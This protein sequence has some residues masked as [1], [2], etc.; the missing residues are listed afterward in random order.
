AWEAAPFSEDTHVGEDTAFVWR[1]DPGRLHAMDDADF[2]VAVLHGANTSAKSLRGRQWERRPL[3]EV[4]RLL[5]PDQRFYAGLRSSLPPPAAAPAPRPR[6][7]P[8]AVGPAAPQADAPAGPPLVSCI[9][10]TADRRRFAERA[11]EYFLRQDHPHRELVIVD[12][13]RDAVEDLAARD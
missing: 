6:P 4:A 5:G 11:V 9:M 10:P 2:Y 1:L 7:P 3:S 13:G 12:D 8:V